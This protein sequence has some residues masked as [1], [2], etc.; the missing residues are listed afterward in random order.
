MVLKLTR[1]ADI[2]PLTFPATDA[3]M[4]EH[5]KTG[6]V[7]RWRDHIKGLVKAN[8]DRDLCSYLGRE[9]RY[10]ERQYDNIWEVMSCHSRSSSADGTGTCEAPSEAS[11]YGRLQRSLTGKRRRKSASSGKPP[12]STVVSMDQARPQHSSRQP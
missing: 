10:S 7:R 5:F 2:L 8:P 12:S 11:L 3:E 1:P 9:R 6:T 4:A